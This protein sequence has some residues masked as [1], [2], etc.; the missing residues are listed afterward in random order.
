MSDGQKPVI[1]AG[2]CTGCTI[3]IDECPTDCLEMQ[4][5]VSVLARA[6]DC[7]SCGACEEAC[8]VSAI[9]LE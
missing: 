8:P 2:A 6:E 3:C 9:T 4:E 7:I 5:D 1:D